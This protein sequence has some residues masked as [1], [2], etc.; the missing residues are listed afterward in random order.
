MIED[1]EIGDDKSKLNRE[2]IF[3]FLNKEARWCKGI[4]R[5]IVERSIDNS[6]CIGAYHNS[7]QVGFGR[8][9]TDYATFGNVVDIF[10]LPEYR[11]NGLSKLIMSAIVEH[12]ELQGLRRITLATSDKQELYAKFGFTP[13]QRPEIFMERHDPNVYQ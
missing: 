1:V 6:L 7:K 2:M 11:K 3:N 8:V 10:V 12:P 4:S 5:E 13:L 9:V